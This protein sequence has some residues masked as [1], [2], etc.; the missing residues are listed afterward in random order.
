MCVDIA[1]VNNGKN[2]CHILPKPT[3]HIANNTID[4][5]E[6]KSQ[7]PEGPLKM[8]STTYCTPRGVRDSQKVLNVW[9]WL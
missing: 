5:N 8:W 1:L 2:G 4:Q 6:I 3:V 7:A 9:V